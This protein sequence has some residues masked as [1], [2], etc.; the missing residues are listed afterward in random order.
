MMF[1]YCMDKLNELRLKYEKSFLTNS[2]RTF[3]ESK[4][5]HFGIIKNLMP[6]IAPGKVTALTR[7]I[8]ST[9]YGN[10]TVTYTI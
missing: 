6:S 3:V 7:N 8:I 2:K 10:V 9:M 4:L 1:Y 5:C